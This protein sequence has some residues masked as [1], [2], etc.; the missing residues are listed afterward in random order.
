MLLSIS[1]VAACGGSYYNLDRADHKEWVDYSRDNKTIAISMDTVFRSGVPYAL[2]TQRN[3]TFGDFI[4]EI[5]ALNGGDRVQITEPGHAGFT[6]YLIQGAHSLDTA[7]IIDFPT[8]PFC[9][10][11]L[12][13]ADLFG[14]AG[15]NLDN[16]KAFCVA[17]P[18]LGPKI[19]PTPSKPSRHP[20]Q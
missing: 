13:T 16:V 3:W 14:L 15:L 4:V 20:A 2:V 6:Q 5:Y 18:W 17:N 10:N 12:V 1:M 9:V 7:C 19:K 8:F 11:P